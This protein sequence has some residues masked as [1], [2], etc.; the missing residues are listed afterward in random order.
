MPE[1][2]AGDALPGEADCRFPDHRTVG[3]K[4]EI[5]L[6]VRSSDSFRSDS[7]MIRM[8]GASRATKAAIASASISSRV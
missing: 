4:P 3:K 7:E 1:D 2:D 5:I 6:L 8:V